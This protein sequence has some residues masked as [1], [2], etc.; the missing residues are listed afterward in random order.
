ME[1][2][3]INDSVLSSHL[4]KDAVTLSSIDFGGQAFTSSF[5]VLDSQQIQTLVNENTADLSRNKVWQVLF[6]STYRKSQPT[7]EVFDTTTWVSTYNHEVMPA[8]EIAVWQRETVKRVLEIAPL[9]IWEI[10]CGSGLLMWQ[11]LDNIDHFYGTDL[12]RDII[13][14]VSKSLADKQISK[15][16]LQYRAPEDIPVFTEPIFEIAIINS[17]AQYFSG[18]NY[19]SR[20]L[21]SALAATTKGLFVGDVRSFAHHEVFLTSVELFQAAD[22]DG[23]DEIQTKVQAK[24]RGEKELLIHEA[25]FFKLA[26]N[27]ACPLSVDA[28]IKRGTFTNEMSRWRYDV[29]LR[30]SEIPN[31]SLKPSQSIYWTNLEDLWNQLTSASAHCIEV[32]DIPNLRIA[33]DVWAYHHLQSFIGTVGEI[34]ARA[35]LETADAVDPDLLFDLADQFNL[36]VRVIWSQK[37]LG[38]L[39]ALFESK[40]SPISTWMP[41]KER[42]PY[43]LTSDPAGKS[44]QKRVMDAVTADLKAKIPE[45]V[46]PNK[47]IKIDCVP[48]TE[49][50]VTDF[51]LLEKI[52]LKF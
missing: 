43:Q 34:K 13:D 24:L 2:S 40:D 38:H 9:S 31:L 33:A 22:H 42:M 11:L 46:F 52:S 10:G 3:V 25:Y 21:Q 5:V 29:S 28:K 1:T 48:L 32:L 18:A 41:D 44:L 7:N 26:A 6:E 30:K 14:R 23:L 39:H 12:S 35:R 4:V 37:H 49:D 50:G 36:R 47:L 17:V 20:V 51:A 19:L 45:N 16:N 15:V 8:A 27:P